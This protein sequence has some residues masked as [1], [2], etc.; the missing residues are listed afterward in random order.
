MGDGFIRFAHSWVVSKLKFLSSIPGKYV[1]KIC[2][3]VPYAIIKFFVLL[4]R[5]LNVGRNE[6]SLL[7]P[8]Q[9]F[10]YYT[11]E[12]VKTISQ[13]IKIHQFTK[14]KP[15]NVSFLPRYMV[16]LWLYCRNLKLKKTLSHRLKKKNNLQI[17]FYIYLHTIHV[18]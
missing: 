14:K 18:I 8:K 16:S 4:F 5:C 13:F 7:K 11:P 17:E 6:K 15:N 2:K 3:L 10:K 12:T 9:K 1:K